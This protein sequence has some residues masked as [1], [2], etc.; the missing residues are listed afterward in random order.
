MIDDGMQIGAL[1]EGLITEGSKTRRAKSKSSV[2]CVLA[3]TRTKTT[4]ILVQP[5]WKILYSQNG[6]LPQIGVKM[7]NIWNHH[8]GFQYMRCHAAE[9]KTR[10]FSRKCFFVP[11]PT[12]INLPLPSKAWQPHWGWNYC[13]QV[14]QNWQQLRVHRQ[15]RRL[16]MVAQLLSDFRF[17]ADGLRVQ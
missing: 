11:D 15:S 13:H 10:G 7:K 4:V 8:P 6:N 16:H 2:V 3:L 9:K 1:K 14:L 17:V 5:L 12:A